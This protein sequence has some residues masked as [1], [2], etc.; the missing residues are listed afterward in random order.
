MTGGRAY[1]WKYHCPGDLTYPPPQFLVDEIAQSP[2]AEPQCTQRRE[3]IG[4]RQ[5]RPLV[6]PCVDKHRNTHTEQPTMKGHAAFPNEKHRYR[7]L[8]I[9]GCVVEQCV[10]EP[11]TKD[12]AQRNVKYKIPDLLCCPA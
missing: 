9:M 3:K 2:C 5:K 7:I 11:A 4:N 10:T 1:G 12:H 6:T 8:H